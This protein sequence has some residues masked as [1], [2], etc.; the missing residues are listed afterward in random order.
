ML[1]IALATMLAATLTPPG[2]GH[3]HP[4]RSP[5]PYARYQCTVRVGQLATALT[6]TPTSAEAEPFEL[7]VPLR[8]LTA[9]E[10]QAH[11]ELLASS[12][13]LTQ[14]DFPTNSFVHSDLAAGFTVAVQLNLTG[15]SESGTSLTTVL[16]VRF[17]NVPMPLTVQADDAPEPVEVPDHLGTR[18]RVWPSDPTHVNLN[19]AIH[20]TV[21]CD[22][23]ELVR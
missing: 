19:G 12:T 14:K 16:G 13:T 23:S 5:I 1:A 21:D 10:Q 7:V 17:A 18:A 22:L 15:A 4:P 8:G 9:S 11:P 2:H 20:G 3:P 6:R